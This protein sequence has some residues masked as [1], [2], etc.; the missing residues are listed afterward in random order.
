MATA[1]RWR[2]STKR[3][4]FHPRAVP[5]A[6]HK[7]NPIPSLRGARKPST[8]RTQFHPRAVPKVL[9]ETNP[10]PPQPQCHPT[11]TNH[12]PPAS[13][14]ELRHSSLL[15]ETTA[16]GRV[17]LRG[18]A[19]PACWSAVAQSALHAARTT[20]T[21]TRSARDGT[22]RETRR[23]TLHGLSESVD[24]PQR[25]RMHIASAPLGGLPDTTPSG[26]G[27]SF[28]IRRGRAPRGR[29]APCHIPPSPAV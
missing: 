22:L 25:L 23:R 20:M 26:G 24:P 7:T 8:K 15:S 3:T 14:F 5:K 16:S 6:L 11:L 9:Y 29:D 19:D 12:A 17:T 13:Y 10:I 18:S 28:V 4:Q 21:P 27:A 2:A 1:I